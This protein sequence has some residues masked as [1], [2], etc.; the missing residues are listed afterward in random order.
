MKSIKAVFAKKAHQ[1]TEEKFHEMIERPIGPLITSLAIPS[2]FANLVTAIYNLVDMYFVGHISTAASGAIGISFVAMTAIQA[3]G[4]YFGQGTGNAISRYLGAKQQEKANI[5]A[6]TGIV[7]TLTV[8]LLIAILG[9]LF[10]EPL[11]ILAGATPTILPYAKTFIGIILCGAPWMA[12]SI[13]LNMQL[14]FEGESLF[15][16]LAITTGAILNAL[17]TPLLIYGFHLGI[18]GSAISTI[19][20]EFIGFVLLL[21]ETQKIGLA[22]L[23]LTWVRPSKELFREINNGGTPSFVRQLMLGIA[24]TLLNNAAAPFGDAAVAA[25]AI[26]QRITG[27]AN[28]IQIGIGQGYQPVLGYNIGA[29]HHERVLAGYSFALRASTIAVLAIGV[30]T[31]IFAPQLI[32]IFRQD[33]QV[34]AIGTLT[35]RLASFS[36]ALTGVAMMTN[37]ML[38]TSGH[39]WSASILGACRLGLVLGPV[40]VVMAYFF[41]LLGVQ[42]A[43]PVADLITF[44]VAI[45]FAKITLSQFNTTAKVEESIREIQAWI[46]E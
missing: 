44:F 46:W 7:C 15:S 33:P 17:L 3:T 26:V 13:L 32:W 18:A 1:T 27:F 37:F 39:V 8:G 12:S 22:P 21:I 41:G 35:L 4:F 38:Q 34:V 28:Y 20:C 9:N 5:M 23:S 24:T 45:P 40:I 16:M 6:S 29:R 31:C 25:M 2:I 11:C 42:L 10:I 30:F 36:A 43:Q 14:R 19:V